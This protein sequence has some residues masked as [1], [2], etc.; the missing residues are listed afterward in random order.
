MKFPG[1]VSSGQMAARETVAEACETRVSAPTTDPARVCWVPGQHSPEV[2]LIW[3][4]APP[5]KP[6]PAY[7]TRRLST[8]DIPIPHS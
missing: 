1:A 3:A 4:A 5:C 2:L 8:V 7:P 6:L